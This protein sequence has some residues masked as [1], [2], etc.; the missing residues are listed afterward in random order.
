MTD[1]AD[2]QDETSEETEKVTVLPARPWPVYNVDRARAELIAIEMLTR[3][4]SDLRVRHATRLSLK[5]ISRLK[6]LVAEEAKN[7][8][9]PRIVCRTPA[10][11]HSR[12]PGA[13]AAPR[14]PGRTPPT[15]PAQPSQPAETVQMPLSLDW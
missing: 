14:L 8:A 1:D 3:G 2:P 9:T 11:A 13:Q 10:R 6:T 12:Q 5:N 15:K 7:P 4:A